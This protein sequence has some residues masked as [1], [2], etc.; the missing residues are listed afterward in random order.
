MNAWVHWNHLLPRVCRPSPRAPKAEDPR[1]VWRGD[2]ILS[3][4]V[5]LT[6]SCA[7]RVDPPLAVIEEERNRLWVSGGNG[8]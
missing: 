1:R 7:W 2:D 3:H 5:Y 8:G 6:T 4:P